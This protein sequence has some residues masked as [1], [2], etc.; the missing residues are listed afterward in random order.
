MRI[1]LL[2]IPNVTAIFHSHRKK[3][4]MM[5]IEQMSSETVIP[6]FLLL[7]FALKKKPYYIIKILNGIL[8][9]FRLP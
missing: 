5:D 1:V 4:E 8:S 2:T 7:L 6:C 9:T 3:Y